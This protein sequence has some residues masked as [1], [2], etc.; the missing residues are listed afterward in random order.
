MSS[1]GA[2]W[3]KKLIFQRPGQALRKR[4]LIILHVSPGWRNN[5]EGFKPE[6]ADKRTIMSLT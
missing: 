6:P 2:G 4:R 5:D 3:K 1:N